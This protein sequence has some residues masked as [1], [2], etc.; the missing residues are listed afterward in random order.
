M[1]A[2]L[3]A[4]TWSV[5]TRDHIS[6]KRPGFGHGDAIDR[7]GDLRGIHPTG[8]VYGG[9]EVDRQAGDDVQ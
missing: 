1:V 7:D 6:I 4:R 9:D 3:P 2:N 5:N 8:I